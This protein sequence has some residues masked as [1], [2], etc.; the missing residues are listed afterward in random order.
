MARKKIDE[1][2]T[3][4]EE[5]PADGAVQAVAEPRR[6]PDTIVVSA[7]TFAE[8]MAGYAYTV[9]AY[10]SDGLSREGLAAFRALLADSAAVSG[11]PAPRHEISAAAAWW[12]ARDLLQSRHR[13]ASL[14]GG[15]V[16]LA[17]AV[18]LQT[19]KLAERLGLAASKDTSAPGGLSVQGPPMQSPV[20][21]DDDS[22]RN[23]RFPNGQAFDGLKR[24]LG[25]RVTTFGNM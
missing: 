18:R 5:L 17:E 16:M 13:R 21:A 6:E 11:A 3:T 4:P 7:R 15:E 9:A 1:P 14:T 2:S 19:P 8:A 24:P 23:M 12:I 22:L 25:P 10:G 20:L